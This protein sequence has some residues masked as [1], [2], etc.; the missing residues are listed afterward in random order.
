MAFLR[1]GDFAPSAQT[2]FNVKS[3]FRVQPSFIETTGYD[4]ESAHACAA[5]FPSNSLARAPAHIPL[6]H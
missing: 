6:A 2:I 3:G 1:A 4:R 5:R